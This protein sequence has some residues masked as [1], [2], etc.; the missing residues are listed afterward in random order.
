MEGIGLKHGRIPPKVG[1]LQCLY[2]YTPI[3]I[4][5]RPEPLNSSKWNSTYTQ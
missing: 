3:P 1:R 2:T 5:I 4:G